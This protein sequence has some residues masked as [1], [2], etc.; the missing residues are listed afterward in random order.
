MI[1]SPAEVD[2][3]VIQ[4]YSSQLAIKVCCVRNVY[5]GW[6]KEKGTDKILLNVALSLPIDICLL[7]QCQTLLLTSLDDLLLS[8]T[9]PSTIT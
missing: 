8:D 3:L 9:L 1:V 6:P 4:R 7:P 5:G 2:V